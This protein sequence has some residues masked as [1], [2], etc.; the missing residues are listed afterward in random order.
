M[1]MISGLRYAAA[2]QAKDDAEIAAR[3]AAEAAAGGTAA[4][5]PSLHDD[6]VGAFS[7]AGRVAVVTGAAG[8]IG[9]EAAVTFAKA[10]ADVAIADLGEAGLEGT[11]AMVRD[12]GRRCL[13]RRTDVSDSADVD[14][15]A[16]A[17]LAEYGR[18]DVW[19]NVAGIIRYFPILEATDADVRSIVDVNQLGVY[20]GIRAAG[21]AMGDA[22]GSIINIASAGGEMGAPMISVYGMTK[23]AVIQLTRGAAVELGPKGIRVNAVAPGFVESP[24]TSI[25]FTDAEGNVDEEARRQILAQ[26]GAQS[27]LGITGETTDITYAMLYLASDAAKFVTGITMRPNGGVIMA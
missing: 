13:V 11:A 9:R 23:A 14:G 20:W 25:Y 7:L 1:D 6:L 12:L 19:A 3:A 10:G 22:G 5:A 8:G 2:Q 21:R 16:S 15:L 17:A 27:P 24:M 4:S 18:I 26:R